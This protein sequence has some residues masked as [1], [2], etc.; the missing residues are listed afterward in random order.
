MPSVG[1]DTAWLSEVLGARVASVEPTATDALDSRTLRLRVGY[2][3]PAC[4]LPS[5]L[6]LKRNED[7]AWAVAAGREEAEFYAF[8]GG[9]VPRPPGIVPCLAS[10]V[11]DVTGDCSC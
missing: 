11:D 8:V 7:A 9:L 1:V 10:G 4:R 2:D 5:A 3:V 6:V